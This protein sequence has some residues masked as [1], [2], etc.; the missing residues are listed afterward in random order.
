MT[1]HYELEFKKKIVR[2]HL[3][4]GRT[5]KGLSAE[6]GVSKASISNWFARFREEC[7]IM[8]KPKPNR[9]I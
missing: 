8:K 3:E 9:T 7:Q 4:A 6:Y 2:L 1:P 5:L